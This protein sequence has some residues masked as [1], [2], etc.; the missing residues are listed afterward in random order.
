[1][2]SIGWS[3]QIQVGRGEEGKIFFFS[4]LKSFFFFFF[5]F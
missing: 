2:G 5:F 4:F 1:M 3:V